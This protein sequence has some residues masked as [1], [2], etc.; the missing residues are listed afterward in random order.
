MARKWTVSWRSEITV[1]FFLEKLKSENVRPG[2]T[3]SLILVFN[4]IMNRLCAVESDIK[5]GPHSMIIMRPKP[6]FFQDS[7][8]IRLASSFRMNLSD[9]LYFNLKLSGCFEYVCKVLQNMVKQT[10]ECLRRWSSRLLDEHCGVLLASCFAHLQRKSNRGKLD[11]IY[12]SHLQYH[13]ENSSCTCT[14]Q[15]LSILHV[16]VELYCDLDFCSVHFCHGC[17]TS[18]PLC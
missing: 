16:P 8:Y 6:S 18:L 17:R 5:F 12:L 3:R 9:R 7:P 2:R 13:V 15:Q 1:L 4:V 10:N 14:T 11:Y